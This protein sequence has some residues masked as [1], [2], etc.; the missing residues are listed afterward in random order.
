MSGHS[1]WSTIKRQKGANDAKRGLLFSKL[2]RGMTLA[3]RKGGPSTD[4]NLALRLLVDKA[5]QSN[6]PK[7]NISR[8]IERA[9]AKDAGEIS[10]VLYEGFG[11][12]GISILVEGATDNKNRTTQEIK[13][14]FEKGGGNMGT[15]GSVA[16]QFE[17]VGQ[18]FI[19]KGDNPEDRELQLIDLGVEDVQEVDDGIEIYT[20][21][22]ELFKIGERVTGLGIEVK[23]KELAYRPKNMM[24][25]TED[26]PNTNKAIKLLETLDENDDVQKV[27][28]N[29]N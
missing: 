23:E 15:Q 8:A 19:E 4:S 7:D 14:I 18:I 25:L 29:F 26:D 3:A 22:E 28:T 5:K 9:T 20:K 6:M 17:R 13:N 2:A 27:Y 21:P 16:F 10:D 11:P 1:K 12:G 24:V